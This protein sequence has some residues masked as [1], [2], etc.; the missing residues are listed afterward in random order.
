MK[1]RDTKTKQTKQDFEEAFWRLY[2]TCPLENI[3]VQKICD[4]AGYTRG[5]FYL[6]FQDIYSLA[7]ITKTKMLDE[8][9]SCTEKSLKKMSECRTKITRIAALKDVISYYESNKQHIE[10]LLGSKENSD[11][12]LQLKDRLKPFWAQYVITNDNRHS[13]KEINLVLE[14]TLAGT[15][16]MVSQWLQ[17]PEGI[18]ATRMGK[19]LYDVAIRDVSKRLTNTI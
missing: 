4:T 13:D 7:E 17:N 14:Y 12:I 8:M 15:L 3:T 5:T 11:F 18:S 16:F 2:A 1:K 10:I 19:L 9:I 6:H